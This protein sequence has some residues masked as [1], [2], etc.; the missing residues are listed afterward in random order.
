MLDPSTIGTGLG[1]A[2]QG[3]D[4]L[5][6]LYELLEQKKPDVGAVKTHLRQLEQAVRQFQQTVYELQKENLELQ[7]KNQQLEMKLTAED[8]WRRQAESV[9]LQQTSGGAAVYRHRTNNFV[10]CPSCYVEK[11]L[12]PLQKLSFGNYKCHRCSAVYQVEP[13]QP[14]A[15]VPV[16]Q[17][18]GLT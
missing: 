14:S 16:L 15:T 10:F 2:K 17:R 5:Q 18:R 12:I 11:K 13:H 3:F 7:A 4:L 8:D 6:K 1:Y 9:E